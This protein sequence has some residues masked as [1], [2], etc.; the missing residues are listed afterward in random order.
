MGR[1]LPGLIKNKVKFGFKK[2][3]PEAGS[4]RVWVFT[5]TQLEPRPG[6]TQLIYIY[7][8][9]CIV[10]KIPSYIYIY[11]VNPTSPYTHNHF[12]SLAATHLSLFSSPFLHTHS[13]SYRRHRTQ[14]TQAQLQFPLSLS[15]RKFPQPPRNHPRSSEI[16]VV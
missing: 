5:K 9:I 1:V 4:S 12:N 16:L 7:I 14:A 13:Q 3:K 15:P 11:I 6:L 10:A 8:Y 2:E